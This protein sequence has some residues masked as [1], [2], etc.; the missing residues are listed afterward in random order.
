ME[1]GMICPKAPVALIRACG[2]S[3]IVALSQQV[4]QRHQPQG[5][6]RGA[7]DAGARGHQGTHE[8][9]AQPQPAGQ[10]AEQ[11]GQGAQQ[12][13]GDAR[14]LEHCTHEDEQRHGDERLIGHDAVQPPRQKAEHV[15]VE[16]AKAGASQGEDERAAGQGQ[17]HGV[18]QQQ[19]GEDQ[20]EQQD[21]S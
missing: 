11:P 14:A 17:G 3:W 21:G 15:Q 12:L 18:A 16:D 13:F 5:H 9:H 6:H 10:T 7:D 1:G 20:R 2:Q 8:D 19:E 4:G